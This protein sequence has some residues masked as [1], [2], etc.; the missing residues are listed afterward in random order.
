MA[1]HVVAS[2]TD[3]ALVGLP[4]PTPLEEWT[5]EYVV[6]L[7]RGLSR[8]VVRI[9]RVKQ[10]TMAIKETEADIAL[11][12]YRLLRDLHRLGMPAVVPKAVVTGR[13]DADGEPLPAALL[14]E[15]LKFSLP[16]RSLFR[17]G[18]DA[19]NLPSL[20]DALVVLLVR[21]HLADFWTPRPASSG[22]RS[23]RRCGSTTSPS[24]PR[25]SS[26]SCSTCRP[27]RSWTP[28][29]GRTRSSTC[30]PSATTRCGP[31]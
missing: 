13:T 23:R 17:H 10:Q 14:T 4:W 1:L 18:L 11:R 2:R 9:V 3:P 27:A 29:S 12:E 15:Y 24:R 6:P 19:S 30:S 25:T 20:V 5:D 31:R 22:R 26:P 16:Y 28:T 7:P 21:L 8:H